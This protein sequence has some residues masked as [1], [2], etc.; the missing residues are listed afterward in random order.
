MLP[1]DLIDEFWDI[2]KR[3]LQ[4]R[5]ELS[6]SNANTAISLYQSALDRHQVGDMVYHR[7]AESVADTIAGGW[8]RKFPD[9]QPSPR[10][11]S[12]GAR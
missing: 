2:V 4:E 8:T 5:H 1:K 3:E 7:N 9:P 10:S 11:G 6:E 12:A